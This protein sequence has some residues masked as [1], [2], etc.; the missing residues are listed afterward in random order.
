[1]VY[2]HHHPSAPSADKDLCLFTTPFLSRA[3]LGFPEEKIR[4]FEE[5]AIKNNKNSDDEK[6]EKGVM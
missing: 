4:L 3:S 6:R 2:C 1:M 5:R